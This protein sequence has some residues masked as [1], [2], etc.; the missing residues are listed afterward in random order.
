M[1]KRIATNFFRFFCKVRET[2][3]KN[4]NKKDICGQICGQNPRK[5]KRYKV[6]IPLPLSAEATLLLWS[7]LWS[8]KGESRIISGFIY[9]FSQNWEIC[10]RPE[11]RG[12]LHSTACHLQQKRS[13]Q[14]GYSDR[15]GPSACRF[16][17]IFIHRKRLA[18]PLQETG[19]GSNDYVSLINY[20]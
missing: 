3:Y 1:L 18:E 6:N 10:E 4:G 12:T 9:I 20:K 5:K 19:V 17:A 16:L 2:E 13:I 15:V 7:N 14:R 8:G 11:T